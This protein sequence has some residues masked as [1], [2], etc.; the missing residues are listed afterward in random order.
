MWRRDGGPRARRPAGPAGPQGG[1]S[2]RRSK[3]P[4]QG[5]GDRESRLALLVLARPSGKEEPDLSEGSGFIC[6]LEKNAG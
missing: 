2:P 3:A 1:T 6:F 4:G 5:L